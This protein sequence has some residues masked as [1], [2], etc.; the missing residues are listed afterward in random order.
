[1]MHMEMDRLGRDIEG[2]FTRKDAMDFRK[3]I[4]VGAV[5]MKYR[6]WILS[7]TSDGSVCAEYII[8][9]LCFREAVSTHS[10]VCTSTTT[11]V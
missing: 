7:N 9:P 3:V 11:V 5:D 6:R 2:R 8:C 4:S 10:S 1:M